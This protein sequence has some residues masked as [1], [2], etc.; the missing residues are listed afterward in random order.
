MIR[1]SPALEPAHFDEK[2]RT[3]GLVFLKGNPKPKTK[4]WKSYWT[5]VKRDLREAYGGICCY[6]ACWISDADID[7]VEHFLPKKYHPDLAY[8]WSN[9]RYCSVRYNGHKSNFMDV[10]DPFEIRKGWL[11]IDFT[12]RRVNV[13]KGAPK[14]RI[15]L[16]ETTIN[17]LKL[18]ELNT[19]I[20]ARE[21]WIKLFVKTNDL[22]W[23]KDYAPFIAAELERQKITAE[24]LDLTI[25]QN[26]VP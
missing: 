26:P 18:N 24:E 25:T 20:K 22:P 4:E 19:S 11:E 1:I 5:H 12:T 9:Y 10:I 21:H 14:K 17:R 7:T 15:A 3:P 2:V 13:G 6:L 8:E 16:L 23:L